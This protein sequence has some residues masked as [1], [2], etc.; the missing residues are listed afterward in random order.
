M[1]VTSLENAVTL[2]QSDVEFF[3]LLATNPEAVLEKM[4]DV[5]DTLD[6]DVSHSKCPRTSCGTSSFIR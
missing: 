3:E 4:G 2:A 1:I 5:A 6:S